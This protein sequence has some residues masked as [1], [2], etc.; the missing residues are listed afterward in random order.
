MT[1]AKLLLIAASSM[2][3]ENIQQ[4]ASPLNLNHEKLAWQQAAN[5]N[6]RIKKELN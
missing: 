1:K 6:N 2:F 4:E 3:K 5:R